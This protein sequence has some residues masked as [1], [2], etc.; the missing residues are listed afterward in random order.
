VP[1]RSEACRNWETRPPRAR[2][3][4]S[5]SPTSG[6][7]AAAAARRR[8]RR[9]QLGDGRLHGMTG[10]QHRGQPG[11]GARTSGRVEQKSSAAAA[12]SSRTRCCGDRRVEPGAVAVVEP[13][14]QPIV[15]PSA[16]RPAR[17]CDPV[18]PAA[19][20]A[21]R[22]GPVLELYEGGRARSTSSPGAAASPAPRPEWCCA[23]RTAQ[24]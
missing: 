4:R 9:R 12:S 7:P 13:G 10:G 1:P 6:R 20:A 22:P 15:A 24:A 16:V 8:S 23:R 14:E 17:R 21:A 2:A 3:G 18:A 19:T 5:G 11:H